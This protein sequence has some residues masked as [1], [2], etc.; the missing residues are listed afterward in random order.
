MLAHMR[1]RAGARCSPWR[2]LAG[3]LSARLP[4]PPPR[5]GA[6]PSDCKPTRSN[7]RGNASDSLAT[8]ADPL[9]LPLGVRSTLPHPQSRS[10]A[11][12]TPPPPRT[13]S[14]TNSIC[15]PTTCNAN[16]TPPLRGPQ[17]PVWAGTMATTLRVEGIR[18]L[19]GSPG[20]P[21]DGFG[22]VGEDQVAAF[23]RQDGAHWLWGGCGDEAEHRRAWQRAA[24]HARRTRAWR[25]ISVR[26]RLLPPA[27][28][29]RVSARC[30]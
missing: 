29:P 19:R 20:A 5:P 18:G 30:A 24:W 8:S 17:S 14:N 16:R 23:F 13:D 11:P 15:E 1:R 9:P 25:V 26:A 2:R 27:C 4:L 22:S 3:W 7:T 12:A 10:H 28:C 21:P 6:Q